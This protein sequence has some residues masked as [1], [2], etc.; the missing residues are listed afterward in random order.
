MSIVFGENLK[1]FNQA[2]LKMDEFYHMLAVKNGLSDCAFWILYIICE[3][4]EGFSQKVLCE[5][6]SV[7]KQTVHSAIRKLEQDGI[8]FLKTGTGRDKNIYLTEKGK[9]FVEEKIALII[10]T[11]NATFACL[12]ENEGKELQRLTWRYVNLLQKMFEVRGQE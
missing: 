8:L 1:N 6:L 9:Q 2:Y 3:D 4:G 7:S 12:G 5:K 11:E 10:A